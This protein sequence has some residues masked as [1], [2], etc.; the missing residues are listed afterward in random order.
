[1]K[2]QG[3]TCLCQLFCGGKAKALART[4]Y[5]N[6]FGVECHGRQTRAQTLVGPAL[7]KSLK[8]VDKFPTVS[9]TFLFF[10]KDLRPI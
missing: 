1:M 5:Q 6:D 3:V 9:P 10:D 2:D 4:S 7:F 8:P